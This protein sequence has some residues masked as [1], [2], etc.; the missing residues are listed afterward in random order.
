VST[1]IATRSGKDLL[2]IG[3]KSSKE[4]PKLTGDEKYMQEEDKRNTYFSQ[5]WRSKYEF[6]ERLNK[7]WNQ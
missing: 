2:N 4:A 5:T 7:N 6:D 1:N 3:S